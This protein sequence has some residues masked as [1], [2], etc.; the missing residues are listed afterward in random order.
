MNQKKSEITKQIDTVKYDLRELEDIVARGS[1]VAMGRGAEDSNINS[2]HI[3]SIGQD[4]MFD[5]S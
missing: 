3:T 5:S 4:Q 1:I 2:Q